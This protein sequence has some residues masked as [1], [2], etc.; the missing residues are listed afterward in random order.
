M[1]NTRPSLLARLDSL[2]N[3]ITA[4]K[5]AAAVGRIKAAEPVPA[6]PGGY[7][8]GSEHPTVHADNGVQKPTEGERSSENEADVKKEQG[9]PSV[10]SAPD[11]TNE[12]RQDQAQ[13]NIGTKATA[14]G[15]D[16][17]VEDDFKGT[18][19]DHAEGGMGGTSHPATTED[20]KKYGAASFREA[21]IKA[22][23][24]ADQILADLAN[25]FGD[26]LPTQPAGTKTAAA[27]APAPAAVV[28]AAQAG[29]ELASM[30]GLSKEAAQTGVEDC[31]AQT[32]HD[33][34]TQA[35]LVA[36]YYSKMAAD[37]GLHKGEDHSAPEDSA[38]G[39]EP[40]GGGGGGAPPAAG[41]GAPVGMEALLGGGAGGGGG[42]PPPG[43]PP[44]GGGGEPGLE[45]QPPTSDEALQ[46]LA[47][48]LQEL[49]IDLDQLAAVGGGAAGGAAGGAPPMGGAPAGM[50]PASDPAA[51][52]GPPA[53]G[54]KL[55]QA[56]RD[57]KRSGKF[58]IKEARTKRARQL[59]DLMKSHLL[60]LVA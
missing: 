52:G 27:A 40:A 5:N 39:S 36:G 47:M 15:E 4:Q 26:R 31:L 10:N 2:S 22:A 45:G 8:G 19:D 51:G 25:G 55:A 1:P 60:E 28:E 34:V 30:L 46:E 43:G 41:G 53:D 48:A 54:P 23:G 38:S 59:R 20:G 6:D 17:A 13:L 35:D 9:A 18:K 7:Q 58:E 14:V 3:E 49:G 33:A 32:I 12:G 37:D 50:P 24:L 56:V 44:P 57:F 16:P 11:A 42:A 29:Y 21:H